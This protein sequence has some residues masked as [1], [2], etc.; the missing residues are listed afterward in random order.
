M[1]GWSRAAGEQ[2]LDWLGQP[3]GLHWLDNGCSSDIFSE[4]LWQ[5]AQPARLDGIDISPELLANARQRLPQRIALHHSDANAL[6][7]C[8]W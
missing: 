7:F 3:H 1:G 8:R 5:Q 6:P 4:L 2:F